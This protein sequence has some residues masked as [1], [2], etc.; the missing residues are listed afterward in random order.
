[1]KNEKELLELFQVEEL[2]KRYEMG[3]PV[4]LGVTVTHGPAGDTIVG[5]ATGTI[6]G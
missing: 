6:G 1:M 3:W 5:T 2:E 4:K